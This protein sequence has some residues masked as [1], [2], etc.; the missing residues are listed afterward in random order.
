M[1]AGGHVPAPGVPGTGHQPTLE[2]A[3]A[4]RTAPVR[5]DIVQ[6]VEGTLHV[7]ER[8]RPPV[9]LHH[10]AF[11]RRH[12]AHRR[13]AHPRHDYPATGAA[14]CSAAARIHS[15]VSPAFFTPTSK[16]S[17]GST[18]SSARARRV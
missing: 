1:R 16:W 17:Q 15:L 11:A 10:A 5:A 9:R 6:T 13:H 18:S 14:N 12:L 2:I 3:L 4:Q 7:E 8:Q